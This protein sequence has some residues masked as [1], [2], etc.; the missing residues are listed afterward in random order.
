M[1]ILPQT[2][3]RVVGS[4]F[5]TL[6]WRGNPIAFLEG[7]ADSGQKAL[8]PGMEAITPLGS[9]HPVE[10]VTG[11]VL[12]AGTL[13]MTIRELWNAPVWE[14]LSG[15]AGL[16]DIVAVW[17]ALDLDPAEVTCQMI[18]MAPDGLTRGKVYHNCVVS[19]ISDEETVTVG[20]LTVARQISVMYTHSTP[21]TPSNRTPPSRSV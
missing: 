2:R 18:I 16:S 20:A 8:A 17:E 1:L 21:I 12:T 5:T 4:G 13:D 15:L 11:R 3:T 19:T 6:N 9:R 14:Q 10:I 7:F